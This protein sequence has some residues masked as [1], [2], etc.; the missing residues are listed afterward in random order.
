MSPAPGGVRV[1]AVQEEGLAAELG[2]V[3]GDVLVVL[4]GAPISSIDDLIT[5]LR[6]LIRAEHSVDAEWIRDGV[7]MTGAS[8]AHSD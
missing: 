5:V 8:F 7:L 3:D 6:V 1:G 2:L 4:A